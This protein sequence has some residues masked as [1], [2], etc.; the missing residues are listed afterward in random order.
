MVCI[1]LLEDDAKERVG[2]DKKC[3]CFFTLKPGLTHDD[4]LRQEEYFLD[5]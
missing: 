2:V 5:T 1:G 3:C 4:V